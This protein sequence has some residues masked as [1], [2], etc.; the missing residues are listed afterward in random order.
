MQL[1]TIHLHT[2]RSKYALTRSYE[3]W[4]YR[5]FL[6]VNKN[7]FFI[8][9]SNL[10]IEYENAMRPKGLIRGHLKLSKKSQNTFK[11]S[12]LRKLCIG[13]VNPFCKIAKSQMCSKIYF[14]SNGP[15]F[16][17]LNLGCDM[18]HDPNQHL[19]FICFINYFI[20]IFYHLKFKLN[21]INCKKYKRLIF[22][23]IFV[24][25]TI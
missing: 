14:L 2:P 6:K 19:H 18:V 13:E 4:H 17:W 3:F 5:S 1:P 7:T 24:G 8:K 12:K 25:T 10:R 20:L 21:Q 9:A 15:S 23:M 16:L 22:V 11:E